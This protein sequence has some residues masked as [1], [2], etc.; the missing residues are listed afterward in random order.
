MPSS[1]RRWR[2]PA[3]YAGTGAP[4]GR[5]T[6]KPHIGSGARRRVPVQVRVQDSSTSNSLAPKTAEGST[7]LPLWWSKVRALNVGFS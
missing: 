7:S 3:D 1:G 4:D 5:R 6:Q 2:L